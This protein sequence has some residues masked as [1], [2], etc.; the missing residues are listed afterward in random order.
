MSNLHDSAQRY[1]AVTR[2][3]HWG[4]AV[5]LVWQFVTVLAHALLEDSA[6]D[7]FA[8]GTHKATGLVL[9][10]L[11]V[12]RLLWALYN[13][14]R[15][16]AAVST[17][18]RLG[19]LALY[20]LMFVIP[21]IALLRQYGSGREF[22][23]FGMTVM[24]GFDGKIEWMIAPASLLHGNLGWLLLFMV[25]GHAAMAFVHRRQGG[26]DVLARMIGR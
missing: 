7:K 24:P 19:H 16:P 22:V 4:M 15:R 17:L 1:G 12:I 5:L 14:N 3:L 11:V 10:A 2:L 8:W 26:E 20:G 18:A 13:R 23:A 25:I 21:F 6:L 9:M